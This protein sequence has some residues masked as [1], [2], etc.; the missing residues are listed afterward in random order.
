MLFIETPL[1]TK[2]VKELLDEEAYRLLQVRLMAS[3]DAGDL[4]EGTG[5]LR[6][7]RVAAKG[8]GA[9]GGARVI[10]YHFTRASQ[11]AMLYI[12]PKNEQT[13]LSTDQRKALKSI[14]EHWR[15]T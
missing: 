3:P 6:K 1:F 10:Y 8:H 12:Y 15:Y 9:R 13:D 5:G 2:R 14:I 7:V 4:I 11:V